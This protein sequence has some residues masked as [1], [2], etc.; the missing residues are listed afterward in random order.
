[1]KYIEEV[2]S[3]NELEENKNNT[4]ITE[5][6]ESMDEIVDNDAEESALAQEVKRLQS[7][8]LL[9]LA[10]ADNARKRHDKQLQEMKDY[11]ISN[12]AKD[13]V[14]VLD[15]MNMALSHQPEGLDGAAKNV[16]MGVQMTK[17]ELVKIFIKYGI[18]EIMPQTGDQFD[19]Q[20]HYAISRQETSEYPSNT[21]VSV[22]QIGYKLKDRLLRPAMVVVAHNA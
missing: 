2:M 9:V 20:V 4:E 6:D 7:E 13:I 1:M 17:D 16:L 22:M 8:V 3:I 10:D 21:I 5:I 11:A 19:A 12:F 18:T 15:N 14:S